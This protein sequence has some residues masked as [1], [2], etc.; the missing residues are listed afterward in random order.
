MCR[1]LLKMLT[2][3]NYQDNTQPNPRK[4]RVINRSCQFATKVFYMCL[5]LCIM[6]SP[7][8]NPSPDTPEQSKQQILLQ[9]LASNWDSLN[10]DQ[11]RYLINAAGQWHRLPPGQQQKLLSYLNKWEQLSPEQKANS[12]R[13]IK[14]F[15][16]LPTPT[17]ERAR[18]QYMHWKSLPDKTQSTLKKRW[19]NLSN[20]EKQPYR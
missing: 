7:P 10:L 20:E 14:R 16:Q 19:Q 8:A 17:K 6:A 9:A 18:A 2:F 5:P 4:V 3:K 12:Q 13:H 15:L 11:Q 1:Q